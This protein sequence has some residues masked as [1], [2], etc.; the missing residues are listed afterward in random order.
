MLIKIKKKQI[1]KKART[2]IVNSELQ[3]RY[4]KFMRLSSL[5]NLQQRN[6]IKYQSLLS[7]LPKVRYNNSCYLTG[8]GRG[9]VREFKIS[10]HQVRDK[11]KYLHGLTNSSW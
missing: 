7:A 6:Y 5:N 9:V 4:Y 1:D 11:F 3:R 8:R 10:R 2:K